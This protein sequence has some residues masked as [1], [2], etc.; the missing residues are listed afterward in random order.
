M[1]EEEDREGAR[2]EEGSEGGRT[3]RRW[4]GREFEGWGPV[5]S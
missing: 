1:S 2:R 4:E 3:T 5:N